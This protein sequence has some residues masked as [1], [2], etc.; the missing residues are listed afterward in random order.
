[1]ITL[2]AAFCNGYAQTAEEETLKKGVD[3]IRHDK[4]DEAIAE[5]DKVIAAN[6]KSASG[7]YNLGFAYDKKGDLEKAISNFSK[8]IEIDLALTD[9]YYNRGF[10]YY[11]KGAFDSAIADYNK[12]IEISPGSA[13]A[14]YGLGLVYSKKGDSEKAISEYTKA[15]KARTNFALAY[16]ARAVE[17]VAKK[18]YLAA[19]ADVNKAKS[20]GFRSRPLKRTS[21][22]LTG[23]GETSAG[24]ADNGSTQ[25]R[26]TPPPA[27]ITAGIIFLIV[28]FLH[29]LRLVFRVKVTIGKFAI[30]LWASA[31]G[32]VILL[33]LSLWMIRAMRE[34]PLGTKW[35][36]PHFS[37]IILP[38]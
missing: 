6:P 21:A 8:A 18:N 15:I 1:M 4:F 12:V 33:L 32:A 3:L 24:P 17:Y 23:A 11:K 36:I 9:A 10:A 2:S 26:K 35:T 30:P 31:I 14:Y 20:L 27:L 7:Y 13:D 37:L 29:L 5:F 25:V 34:R 38:I 28:C 16:D 19:L 22:G